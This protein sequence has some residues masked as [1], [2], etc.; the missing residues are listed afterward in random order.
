M[1]KIPKSDMNS[2]IQYNKNNYND[3]SSPLQHQ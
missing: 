2:R 1:P 3:S